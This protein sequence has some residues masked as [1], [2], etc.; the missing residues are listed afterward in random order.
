MIGRSWIKLCNAMFGCPKRKRIF[1]IK[2]KHNCAFYHEQTM[3]NP[4]VQQTQ[5]YN[6]LY[7]TSAAALGSPYYYGY[8]PRGA[9]PMP[10]A[11]RFQGPSYLYYPAQVEGS[12]SAY[13]PTPHPVPLLQPIRHS[14]P[15]S[16]GNLP[17]LFCLLFVS[18]Y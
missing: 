17:Y 6:Q 9:F 3:Y 12:S 15:S 13:P 1:L 8:S 16:A 18:C 14:L 4:H 10:A 7:G 2:Q 11:H 5:Y